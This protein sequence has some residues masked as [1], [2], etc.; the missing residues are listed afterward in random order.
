[1]EGRS[2]TDPILDDVRAERGYTLSYHEIFARTEPAFLRRYAELYRSFTLDERYLSARERE[3]V[4]VGIL[5][6][7][8]EAVGTLHLERALTAG[9]TEAE[10]GDAVGV[11]AVAY[12]WPAMSFVAGA[13]SHTVTFPLWERYEAQLVAA[14]PGL[15]AREIELVALATQAALQHEPAFLHHLARLYATETPEREIAEAVSYLL[16]PKG[17]NA[18]LW[19]TDSW[20]AAIADGHLQPGAELDGVNTDTRRS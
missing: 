13:W 9:I 12:G 14:A 7:D 3:L 6:A 2:V 1:M 20:L 19:A 11:A 16:L 17:A 15:S 8:S 10:I 18:M 4:W 5:V